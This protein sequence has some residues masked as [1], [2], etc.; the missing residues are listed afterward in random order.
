MM[1]PAQEQVRYLQLHPHLLIFSV[2]RLLKVQLT[3]HLKY[4]ALMSKKEVPVMLEKGGG[5][6]RNLLLM[7]PESPETAYLRL[8][9]CV[10]RY[11]APSS[12]IPLSCC[13]T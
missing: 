3:A 12:Q 2:R 9:P 5:C 4:G 1:K 10:S 8:E 11:T 6:S 7:A 13:T